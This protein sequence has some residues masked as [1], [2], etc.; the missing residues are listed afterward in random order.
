MFYAAFRG[1][2]DKTIERIKDAYV[3]LIILYL[4][5][6]EAKKL[7]SAKSIKL[8]SDSQELSFTDNQMNTVRDFAGRIPVQ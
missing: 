6:S 4:D 8:Q 1:A 3:E 2:K 5:P 7:A